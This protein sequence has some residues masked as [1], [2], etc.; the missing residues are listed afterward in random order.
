MAGATSLIL[1]FGHLWFN[2]VG[3]CRLKGLQN[4]SLRMCLENNIPGDTIM[5]RQIRRAEKRKF[6]NAN[7]HSFSV[8]LFQQWRKVK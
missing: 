6:A 1:C 5:G 2:G 4:G 8:G 3:K 7:I